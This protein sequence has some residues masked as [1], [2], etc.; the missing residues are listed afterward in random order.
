MPERLQKKMIRGED[1]PSVPFASFDGW[2]IR[3]PIADYLNRG[4][5]DFDSY[6]QWLDRHLD[7]RPDHLRLRKMS[8]EKATM[9]YLMVQKKVNA[10]DC[11]WVKGDYWPDGPKKS[12]FLLSDQESM[13]RKTRIGLSSWQNHLQSSSH[14]RT[15]VLGMETRIWLPQVWIVIQSSFVDRDKKDYDQRPWQP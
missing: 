4:A 2:A 14:H 5:F 8:R 6:P 3:I 9:G 7:L 1:V 10:A 13:K 15:H 12:Y 11:C